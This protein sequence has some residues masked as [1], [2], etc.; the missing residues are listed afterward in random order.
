MRRTRDTHG[1]GFRVKRG[2]GRRVA[3]GCAAMLVGLAG[4][5]ATDEPG[6]LRPMPSPAPVVT[7]ATA[8]EPT[9]TPAP[10]RTA[11]ARTGAP[12]SG[13]PPPTADTRRAVSVAL[14]A[15]EPAGL[16]TPT[17]TMAAAARDDERTPTRGRPAA[18]TPAGAHEPTPGA[19]AAGTPDVTPRPTREGTPTA[20]PAAEPQSTPEVEPART[21]TVASQP[22][23][24]IVV[25]VHADTF[26]DPSGCLHGG[27]AE[28]W[29]GQQFV[30][31]RPD[32]LEVFFSQGGAVYAATANGS[33]IRAM[34]A[35]RATR[36]DIRETTE[37]V[38]VLADGTRERTIKDTWPTRPVEQGAGDNLGPMAAFSV[39][40]DGRQLVYSTCAFPQQPAVK[41]GRPL[42][43]GDF[44]YDL[45]V[46]DVA[47]GTSRRLTTRDTFDNFAA[48]SPDGSRIAFLTGHSPLWSALRGAGLHHVRLFTMA[49][50]GSD[51]RGLSSGTLI[52]ER[53]LHQPQWSPD[54]QRVAFVEKESAASR[55]MLVTV[56][57]DGTELR[58]LAVAVSPPSWSPDG[59]RLAVARPV[60]T[61][62][63]EL[64]TMRADGTDARAVTAIDDWE[65]TTG[66]QRM[67]RNE[68]E[69]S[70]VIR[71]SEAWIETLAWSPA[72]D[73]ILYSCG[74]G[75]CVVATDGTP[76]GRSPRYGD[77][78]G[79]ASAIRRYA[80][81]L[82]PAA[83]WSPDGSRI[84]VVSRRTYDAEVIL[85]HAA[86]DWTDPRALAWMEEGKPPVAVGAQNFG[87][88]AKWADCEA[89]IVVPQPEANPGLVRDC[90]VLVGLRHTI[91]AQGPNFD[92]NADTPID[93][94]L[95]V[96]VAGSPPRV[97]G[98][99][100][101]D[102]PRLQTVSGLLPAAI[103]DLTEL[104]KLSVTGRGL[105]GP[106]PAHWGN[107]GRLES[108]WLTGRKISGPLPPELG[109]LRQLRFLDIRGTQLV[110]PIPP[111]FGR[112]T[113]LEKAELR[114]NALTGPIPPSFG[115]L[116]SL[117]HV[118]LRGN[119]LTGCVPPA[120]PV[121]DRKALGL[122]DCEAG[123]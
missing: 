3:G 100:L 65:L 68:R 50:D 90:Q 64:I 67:R 82:H 77:E 12:R 87:I 35:T 81:G 33:G 39:S 42:D 101:D 11:T 6:R 75:F 34:V 73:Q 103:G 96:D 119:Q 63:V 40:P 48:W 37:Y 15:R 116:P 108:L 21:A 91:F 57:A 74:A 80:L 17:P 5:V 69:G 36:S 49:F 117:T 32:G 44:Q 98:L 2:L 105:H 123:G 62:A 114:D 95:N 23:R 113:R 38:R 53:L 20:T 94:W 4:C 109:N 30:A 26:R 121:L 78:T 60:G 66:R 85:Q 55:P 86:P 59:R 31:W 99:W 28:A 45:A 25:R 51:V 1:L 14:Q 46:V 88:T 27:D 70:R 115:Q 29:Q 24:E 56:R 16:P 41:A 43:V 107:L 79:Q 8:V 47:D 89:G 84:A 54:G 71:A 92:W 61:E 83:A 118:Y 120:L 102:G 9:A 110:G 106:I 22:G 76:V 122:P 72:G 10:E 18:V 104:Q 97:T 19:R 52:S 7:V 93:Q 111:E 58:R 13:P 112:L